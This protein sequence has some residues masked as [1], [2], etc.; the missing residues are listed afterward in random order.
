MPASGRSEP[1]RQPPAQPGTKERHGIDKADQPAPQPM[2]VFPEVDVL[3]SARLIPKLISRYCGICWYFSNSAAQC[4]VRQRRHDAGDRLPFG[5]RQPD[6]VSRVTP[7]ITTIAKISAQQHNSQTATGP[8]PDL[9][10]TGARAAAA[11]VDGNKRPILA[12]ADT[13]QGEAATPRRQVRR[14]ARRPRGRGSGSGTAW[15]ARSWGW[16]RTPP[17]ARARRSRRGP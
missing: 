17:A 6:R 13:G 7:P 15:C 14:K 12:E 1:P 5:D 11:I 16:R 4:G 8:V 3:N 9:A 2:H 10:C